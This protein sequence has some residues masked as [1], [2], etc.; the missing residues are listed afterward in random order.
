MNIERAILVGFLGN[1]LVNT[2]IAALVALVPA[3]ASGGILTPQYISFVVLAAILVGLLAWWY[4]A[5]SLQNGAV[6]GVVGFLVAI[7]TAFVTGVAGVLAQ[8]GSLSAVVGVLPNFWPFLA[9]WSTAV[10][11]G[12]WIIP[13]ALIGWYMQPKGAAA[14]SGM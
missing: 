1:Y 9:N 4:G 6:F 8:T 11:A 12:Y 3:S 2:V 13:A 14:P 10:L 7:A 5:R